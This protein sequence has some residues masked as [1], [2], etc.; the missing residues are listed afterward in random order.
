MFGFAYGRAAVLKSVTCNSGNRA[1]GNSAVTATGTASV[2]H[3]IA[4]RRVTPATNQPMGD[5]DSGLG[6]IQQQRKQ[7]TQSKNLFFYKLALLKSG[8]KHFSSVGNHLL[9]IAMTFSSGNFNHAPFKK[10]I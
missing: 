8:I 9:S 5:N 1:S 2:A 7:L 3:Q 4:M 10:L 6:L